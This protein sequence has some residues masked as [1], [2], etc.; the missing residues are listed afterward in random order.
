MNF[1]RLNDRVK[2]CTQYETTFKVRNIYELEIAKFMHSFNMACFLKTLITI[3]SL[4]IHYTHII[5]EPL[6]RMAIIW[7]ELIRKVGSCH[8]A[9][10]RRCKSLEQNT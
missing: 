8:V 4:Q 9:Y 7:K 5:Q 10:I 6:V 3:L 1:K 2:I